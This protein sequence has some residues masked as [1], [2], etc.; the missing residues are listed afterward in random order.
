VFLLKRR[1]RFAINDASDPSAAPRRSPNGFAGAPALQGLGRHYELEFTCKGDL[2]PDTCYL[3]DIKDADRAVRDAAVPILA[4]ASRSAPSASPLPLMPKI[5]HALRQS[6]D[7]RAWSVRLYLTPTYSLEAVMTDPA[8]VLLRQRFDFAAAHR[9]HNPT[10]SDADNR[11]RFGKCNNP[12][13]HGHN[14]QF[15]PC[16]AVAPDAST[17]DLATLESLAS[18]ILLDRF[19][20]THLNEDTVEFA[21]GTGAIPSVENIARVFFTL[22]AP[23][24][25]EAGGE[26]R[27]MTVWETDRTSATYPA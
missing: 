13:G 26:L 17:F 23:A 2:N 25:R 14:Y 6:L 18:T 24:V 3:V 9:L 10:L 11:A 21:N 16:V 7:A 8:T 5:L 1:V 22:L 19:D 15:E 4:H 20:H 27:S 12:R